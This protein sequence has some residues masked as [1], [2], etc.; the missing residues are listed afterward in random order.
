MEKI[1]KIKK[2][3]YFIV[4]ILLLLALLLLLIGY[5]NKINSEAKNKT[6]IESKDFFS[7]FE[8]RPKITNENS[9]NKFLLILIIILSI[10]FLVLF[11]V[12]LIRCYKKAP[13]E[14]ISTR[15]RTSNYHRLGA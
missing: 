4:N 15:E 7:T 10:V 2:S 5:A 13:K 9:K 14:N 3:P 8:D 12:Y 1:R 6:E 11:I